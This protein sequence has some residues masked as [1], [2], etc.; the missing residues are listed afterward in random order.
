MTLIKVVNYFKHFKVVVIKEQNC[1]KGLVDYSK[2]FKL[3]YAIKIIM[4]I[5]FKVKKLIEFINFVI[6]VEFISFMVYLN[7]NFFFFL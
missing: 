2:Q 1:V 6:E 7:F 5:M 4:K 3:N